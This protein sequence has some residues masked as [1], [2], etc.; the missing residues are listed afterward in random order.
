MRRDDVMYR[1][2]DFLWLKVALNIPQGAGSFYPKRNKCSV[3]MHDGT[4]SLSENGSA[5]REQEAS[6]SEAQTD[7]LLLAPA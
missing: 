4:S 2:R 7:F 1:N 6:A 3:F 5:V